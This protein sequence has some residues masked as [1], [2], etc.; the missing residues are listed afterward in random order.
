M[1][2]AAAVV[3]SANAVQLAQAA[4][5]DVPCFA[6]LDGS[7]L[8]QSS[9]YVEKHESCVK[10]LGE[11][12]CSGCSFALHAGEGSPLLLRCVHTALR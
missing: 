10:Y 11:N 2:A 12:A 8:C 6:A 3:L 9:A 1:A 7:A 5:R 4:S